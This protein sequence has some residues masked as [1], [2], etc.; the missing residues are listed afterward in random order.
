MLSALLL[1]A[2]AMPARSTPALLKEDGVRLSSAV[3][4]GATNTQIAGG[5]RFYYIRGS[6]A[7]FSAVTADGGDTFA[8]DAGV[9][10]STF[11]EPRVEATSITALSVLKRI[12]NSYLMLYSAMGSTGT[13]F[14]IYAATSA[15]GLAWSNATG[16]VIESNGGLGF[17]GSPAL[18]RRANG[19]WRVYYI[20]NR[21]GGTAPAERRIFSAL[22]SNQGASFSAGTRVVDA[23]AGEV[24]AVTLTNDKTRLFYTAPLTGETTFST[25]VSA[26]SAD[27]DLNGTVFNLETGVRLSTASSLGTVHNPFVLRSTDTWR[28]KLY[29]NFNPFSAPASTADVYS[30]STYAPDPRS[31][32]PAAVLRTSG[33]LDFTVTGEIFSDAASGL[34]TLQLS[35]SATTIAGAGLTRTDDQT[36]DVSFNLQ[37]QNLGFWDLVATNGNGHSATLSNA[38]FVDFAPGSVRLTDNLM[39]PRLGTRARIDAMTFKSGR[40]TIRLYT[41]AGKPVATLLDQDVPEGTTTV[42]WDGKTGLGNTVA[43]GV[44]LLHTVGEK[45]NSKDKI[46]VVK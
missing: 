25:I 41:L 3:L 4:A 44:Y 22:S 46:V 20:G 7:V 38:V 17:V 40:M 21:D 2:M 31:M 14:R 32:S 23:L 36:L 15:D 30:A 29:Y 10:L 34:P 6:T 9:R 11:T 8:D 45:L 42:F 28:W 26:L 19:D 18:V 13:I 33:A 12:D 37:G 27:G 24:A 39:R 35:Q 1:L 5:T 43:S 16:T